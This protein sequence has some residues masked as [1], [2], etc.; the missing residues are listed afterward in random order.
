M[1]WAE[2][3]RK[4][5]TTTV[6]G[7]TCTECGATVRGFQQGWRAYIGTG[8]SGGGMYC[9]ECA[10]RLFGEDEAKV[11]GETPRAPSSPRRK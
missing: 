7:L 4:R 11:I 6:R 10:E 1:S 5:S 9:G 8:E 2:R 3:S